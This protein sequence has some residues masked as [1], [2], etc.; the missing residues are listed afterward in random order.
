M[1]LLGLFSLFSLLSISYA[2]PNPHSSDLP[3]M[4]TSAAALTFFALAGSPILGAPTSPDP[5]ATD[6]SLFPSNSPAPSL[7]NSPN[8]ADIDIPSFSS[9]H[10]L[11]QDE[12]GTTTVHTDDLAQKK[13][14]KQPWDKL[15]QWNK[16]QPGMF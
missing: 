9:L 8:L 11:D 3:E 6:I 2:I 1:A 16:N 12:D 13:E 7:P 10:L 15:D 4:R 5:S 14:V